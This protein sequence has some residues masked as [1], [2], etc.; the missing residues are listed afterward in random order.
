MSGDLWKVEELVV[1]L[2]EFKVTFPKPF[3]N[4]IYEYRDEKGENRIYDADQSDHFKAAD[5]EHDGP[6]G[7]RFLAGKSGILRMLKMCYM[8]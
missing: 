3:V 4:E 7:V 2:M 5:T 6:P 8:N 1:D